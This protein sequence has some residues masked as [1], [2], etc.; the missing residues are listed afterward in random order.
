M[1]KP[2]GHAHKAAHC[3]ICFLFTTRADYRAKW[4]GDPNL[5]NEPVPDGPPAPHAPHPASVPLT[6]SGKP[7]VQIGSARCLHTGAAVRGD[8]A[9]DRVKD[10][11]VCEKG[12]GIVCPC[13]CS[14]AKCKDYE[15]DA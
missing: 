3:H 4:G 14:A 2:C 9:P 8:A 1:G 10:W 7:V 6:A 12:H 11:R 13:Q 15:A 5:P